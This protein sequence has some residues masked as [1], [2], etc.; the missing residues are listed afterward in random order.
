MDDVD[1][2]ELSRSKS[3]H[4]PSKTVAEQRKIKA[5]VDNSESKKNRRNMTDP[6]TLRLAELRAE[7]AT[8]K[9]REKSMTNI[10]EI[11]NDEVRLAQAEAIN[12]RADE[13]ARV[14]GT[15][16]VTAVREVVR[17]SNG[18]ALDPTTEQVERYMKVHDIS[19]FGV[20]LRGV[21]QDGQDHA[22]AFGSTGTAATSVEDE[23]TELAEILKAR[24]F[25]D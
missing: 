3:K 8:E 18:G 17:L 7:E 11:R 12:E 2:L 20:A 5:E 24:G 19:D 25:D 10:N 6:R 9:R 23:N 4:P 15:D 21:M 13:F 22:Q 1:K 16:H 14:H